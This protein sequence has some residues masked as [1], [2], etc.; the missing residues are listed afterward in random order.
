MELKFQFILLV[1][2]EIFSRPRAGKE[3]GGGEANVWPKAG[4]TSGLNKILSRSWAG[5]SASG[6]QFWV[7]HLSF[8]PEI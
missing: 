6:D 2:M 3:G 8:V 1:V 4:G 7:S 5:Y